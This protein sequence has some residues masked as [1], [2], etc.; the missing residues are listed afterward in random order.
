ERAVEAI[1]EAINSPLLEVDISSSTGVLV[2]VV[3]GEDMSVSEAERV[4]EEVQTRVSPNARII[5]GAT[6]D[7]SLRH[8]LRIMLVATG[9]R[10]KQILGRK[11]AQEVKEKLG[12]DFVG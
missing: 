8:V 11:T 9:V 7:P 4:A 10:S 6:V 12:I 3:G 2:N 5:W 1:D